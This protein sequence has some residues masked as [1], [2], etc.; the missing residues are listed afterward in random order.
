MRGTLHSRTSA[1]GL[2]Q[3]QILF[4]CLNSVLVNILISSISFENV[5]YHDSCVS[6]V[7]PVKSDTA[8][9]HQSRVAR[10]T[11]PMPAST[12]KFRWHMRTRSERSLTLSLDW[13]FHYIASRRVLRN[14]FIRA[15]LAVMEY[16]LTRNWSKLSVRRSISRR[17]LRRRGSGWRISSKVCQW[18]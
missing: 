12:R 16:G 3:H 17:L 15:G 4:V 18:P 13:L 9:I 8:E 1:G 6:P 14:W 10:C 7:I 2:G 5:V 11:L